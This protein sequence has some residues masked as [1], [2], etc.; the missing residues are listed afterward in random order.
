MWQGFLFRYSFT[1]RAGSRR[2]RGG[3]FVVSVR[4]ER[5][6]YYFSLRENRKVSRTKFPKRE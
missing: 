5:M 3:D 4:E 2:E 1:L 6:Y